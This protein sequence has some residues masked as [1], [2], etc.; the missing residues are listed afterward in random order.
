VPRTLI[1]D[2]HKS[3]FEISTDNTSNGCRI[4]TKS[5]I[6]N[7]DNAGPNRKDQKIAT[8]LRK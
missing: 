5:H 4:Y 2:V 8:N 7:M 6:T 1:L 3:N